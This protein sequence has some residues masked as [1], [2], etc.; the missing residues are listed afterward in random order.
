MTRSQSFFFM[1][2]PSMILVAAFAAAQLIATFISVWAT[3][4]FTS[5]QGCGW[6]WAGIVWIWN[7]VWF[8]PLDFL[9]VENQS[10]TNF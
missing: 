3:W 6:S 7:I 9:K 8:F 2:R 5:I 10:K 4:S 1:E